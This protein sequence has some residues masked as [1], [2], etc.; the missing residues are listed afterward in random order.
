MTEISAPQAFAPVA[1]ELGLQVLQRDWLS[2]N[3]VIFPRC[4]GTP[5]T[6]VD[7]GYQRHAPV[8]VELLERATKPGGVEL[9]IN[10]HL[11]SDHCGGNRAIQ[12][13]WPGCRTLVPAASLDAVRAWDAGQLTYEDTGQSCPRF[14]A[15]GALKAGDSMRLGAASWQVH[16]APG[17]D[18]EAIMLYEPT[19]RVLI[20]GDALWESRLAIIFPE[21]DGAPGF[22]AASATLGLIERLAPAWVIPGHGAPFCAVGPAIAASRSRLEGYAAAPSRHAHH[23]ARA[24]LM[25]HLLEVERCSG[26][27]LEAWLSTTPIFRRMATLAGVAAEDT[28]WA[29][30]LLDG[31]VAEGRLSRVDGDVTLPAWA[32]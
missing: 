21:L 29:R 9:V 19:S 22:A 18:P 30:S 12:T 1:L 10:T 13:R 8:T 27:D 6:V 24:L 7:T 31:L 11:H 3:Q 14:Q 28:D 16:A 25:F 5:A 32:A 26:A 15:D 20:A 17:H 4:A 2:S 23:A